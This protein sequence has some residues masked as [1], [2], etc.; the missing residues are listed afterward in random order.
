MYVIMCLYIYMYIYI[1][2]NKKHMHIYIYIHKM[3]YCLFFEY[4]IC[5][6]CVQILCNLRQDKY[7]HTNIHTLYVLYRYIVIL[8]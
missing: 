2:I 3:Y 8:E 1:Y 7:E 4:S 6:Y 5:I